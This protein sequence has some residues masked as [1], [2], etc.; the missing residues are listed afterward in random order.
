MMDRYKIPRTKELEFGGPLGAM[1]LIF[2]MPATVFYL[3]LT[4]R[5][6]QASVLNFPPPLPPLSTLWSP[7]TFLLLLAWVGLQAALYMLPMGKVTEGIVLRDKSRLQYRINAFHAMGVTALVVGAGLAA[8]LRLSYI[9]D[10]FLQLAFSALLLAFGLSFLLYFKSLF[11]PETTLAPGGNS[12]NPI[13]DFF[14][15]HELNPRIGSFDLKYFCEL[16]PGLLGWALVN[17]AMLVK[18]TELRG[19]PSLAMLLVNAFQLLYVVDALWNE[20][21]ILTTMDIV[22]DGFGF[23]LTFGDLAWVPFIYSLQAYFLV[24]HPQ[25]LSLPMAAGILLLNGLG[26]CIFR[27]ANS[28]KNTFRRNPNDPRVTGL[29]TIPTATGRRLLVSGWW[30]FVRHP[31]YL[32]DLIMALAWSLP[33]GLTHVLPYFYVFYFTVLLIHREA[34]DEHQ[35][36]RKYGLA[37]QEYC[38]RVPYRIFPY[39]Y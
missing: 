26:Y 7:H 17:M 30:G 4:C 23:M 5:T 38:Q 9:Y 15:G 1:I 12:G 29:K 32:G 13:Y 25:K 27:S 16:R 31:N 34:R 11:A 8:G 21:A 35:C 39:L 6:E 10:H 36:L 33:C 14:M 28:Q 22:H 37:W 18:E 20:E 19:S 3:L 24:N 2:L